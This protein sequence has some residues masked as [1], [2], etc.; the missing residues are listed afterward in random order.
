MSLLSDAL[1][2]LLQ[3]MLENSP[4]GIFIVSTGGVRL[5]AN[6]EFAAL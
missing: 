5:Q 4:V 6:L 3:V 2:G 1:E